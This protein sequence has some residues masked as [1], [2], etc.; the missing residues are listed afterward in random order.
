MRRN[1]EKVVAEGYDRV[2]GAYANLEHETEWPRTRWLDDLLRRL[3]SRAH[4]LDLGCGSGVPV[5]R[6]LVD[7]GHAVVGVDISREQLERAQAN[8]PAAE[9]VL[10]SALAVDLAA[11]SLDAVVAF[12]AIDHIPRAKHEALLASIHRWLRDEGWLL[13]TF[14]TGD[15]PGVVGDWLGA[16]MYFS[17]FN[18]ATSQE[19]VR[20]AGFEIVRA[21]HESQL[22]RGRPVSYL[23]VLA[24]RSARPGGETIG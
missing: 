8:V 22:E 2:A 24:R 7:H 3:P 10:A 21:E 9:L 20:R 19:L 23:W 18:A 1:V 12:Y 16:P 17:H 6:R 14:E 15:E 13:V 5:M 11:E 4:V